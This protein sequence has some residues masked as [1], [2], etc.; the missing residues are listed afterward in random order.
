VSPSTDFER[1]GAASKPDGTGPLAVAQEAMWYANRLHPRRLTYNETISIRKDGAFDA[2]VLRRT[3]AEIVRRHES[4]RTHIRVV[5]G[6]PTQVVGPVPEFDLPVIDLG[7]LSAE[8]A[9]LEAV[10]RVAEVAQARYD[11]RSDDLVRPRLFRFPE[12]HHRLYLSMHHIA[13][14]GVSLAQVVM[15][16][17]AAIY[18]AFD[19]SL[20]SPLPDPPT[21][22]VDYA[23]WEQ[24]WIASPRAQ[25]RLSYWA[26][27]LTSAP[28]LPIPLDHERPEEPK[29][30]GGAVPVLLSRDQIERLRELGRS[31]DATLFQV[32]AACW[33][34]LLS[35]Y[36]GRAEVV[37]ATAADLRQRPELKAMVGCCLSPLVMQIDVGDDLAFGDLVLRTRNE[38]LD[39]LDHLVP[40]ER[41][42]RHLP[43]SE[44]RA[45]NPVYQTMI[46]LEPATKDHDPAWSL[47]QIDSVLADACR[48]S[49]LDLE[50]QLDVRS[51]GNLI[52]QLVYDRDLFETATARRIVEYLLTICAA[53]GENPALLVAD[54]PPPPAVAAAENGS[55]SP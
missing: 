55:S 23:R 37:Y 36:A 6:R 18:E 32:L 3:L 31:S 2:D 46:V 33:S 4:L 15:P 45:G 8:E 42:A 5:D 9:E 7:H 54:I 10:R 13:F 50:L 14:D 35:R 41:V 25:R 38:L 47:H 16:E 22:Y 11:L 39:G 49:K 27:R 52:G 30:G 20:P 19:A 26:E 12:E 24:D 17:F 40:F 53:V 29:L 34:V 51:E 21:R 44:A 1:H 48:S 28:A 43:P